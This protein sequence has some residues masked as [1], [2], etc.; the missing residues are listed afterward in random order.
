MA[1]YFANAPSQLFREGK[2][3]KPKEEIGNL[4]GFEYMYLSNL[5]VPYFLY[6]SLVSIK[7]IF[8]GATGMATS[9]GSVA[10]STS[11]TGTAGMSGD[12]L[13]NT[14][15]ASVGDSGALDIKSGSSLSALGSGIA[16]SVGSGTKIGGAFS[17]KA[18]NLLQ[19]AGGDAS[20]V[21]RLSLTSSGRSL[22]LAWEMA[23]QA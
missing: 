7:V 9:L 3:G 4:N 5:K 21:S 10:V 13:L 8:M 15:T 22:T 11:N 16:I 2:L 20:I 17:V 6:S 23:T 19:A 18:G 12:S 1:V 14:G